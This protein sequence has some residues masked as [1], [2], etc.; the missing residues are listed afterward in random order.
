M[1]DFC[2]K[3]LNKCLSRSWFLIFLQAVDAKKETHGANGF[4]E[5]WRICHPAP[6]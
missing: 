3:D 1:F 6:R 2:W 5:H 4:K